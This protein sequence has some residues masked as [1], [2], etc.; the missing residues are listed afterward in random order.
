M[1]FGR[2]Y[3]LITYKLVNINA[4]DAFLKTFWFLSI[5]GEVQLAKVQFGVHCHSAMLPGPW[6]RA[7]PHRLQLHVVTAWGTYWKPRETFVGIGQNHVPSI[8]AVSDLWA[9]LPK[10]FGP[11]WWRTRSC[12]QN[13]TWRFGFCFVGEL[14]KNYDLIFSIEKFIRDSQNNPNL[15]VF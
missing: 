8:L 13:F 11:K 15:Y 4:F 7:L 14:L 9:L 10:I 12:M 5:P 3:I 2:L 6:F 1:E